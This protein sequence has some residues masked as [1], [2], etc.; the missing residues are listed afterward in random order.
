MRN[1]NKRIVH[2]L[3]VSASAE[4]R[5]ILQPKLAAVVVLVLL[6][7]TGF[8]ASSVTV[9][10]RVCGENGLVGRSVLLAEFLRSTLSILER[11][12]CCKESRKSV[13]VIR[14][15]RKNHAPLALAPSTV[16]FLLGKINPVLSLV[17]LVS[18]KE[19]ETLLWHLLM[20]ELLAHTEWSTNLVLEQL[21]LV[22]AFSVSGHSTDLVQRHANQ[23]EEPLHI[24]HE[25]DKLSNQVLVP[26]VLLSSLILQLAMM[27]PA[28]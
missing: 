22:T 23:K 28:L 16:K 6:F 9:M 7:L 4:K 12:T 24:K 26:T 18:S 11:D 27:Y 20:V 17:V 14:S 1:V 8:L 3:V 19:Q 13:V 21:V 15:F 5:E 2:P 25:Q 10:R